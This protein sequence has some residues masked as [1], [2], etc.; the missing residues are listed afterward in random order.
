MREVNVIK[1]NIIMLGG[2]PVG[3]IQNGVAIVDERFLSKEISRFLFKRCKSVKWRRGVMESLQ[4]TDDDNRIPVRVYQLKPNADP[5][6]KFISLLELQTKGGVKPQNYRLVFKGD[7]R[8]SKIEAVYQSL[9]EE[10]PRGFAGHALALSDVIELDGSFYYI[11][12]FSLVPIK[13][14]TEEEQ[15]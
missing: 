6:V 10:P 8:E 1:G 14:E 2:S 12:T 15:K 13:F 3:S 11:D 9:R 4:K 7:T 5:L